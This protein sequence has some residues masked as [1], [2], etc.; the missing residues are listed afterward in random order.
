MGTDR[1]ADGILIVDKPEGPT[2]HDVVA[3]ARRLLGTRR[4][5][6]AGTLDPM[7]TGVLVLGYGRGTRLLPHL[8]ATRKAYL[9]TIRLGVA[10]T[11]DDRTG[12]RLWGSAAAGLTAQAVDAAAR[13]YVGRIA[14]R[15]S[16]V[17]AIKVAGRRAHARV[18]DG[19]RLDLPPREVTVYELARTGPLRRFGQWLDFDVTVVCSAGTYIRALARDI[20][21]DLGC[22]GHLT[23]LRRTAVGPFGTAEAA[24]LERARPLPLAEAAAAVMPTVRLGPAQAASVSHGQ[25]IPCDT[26]ASGPTALLGPD[27]D[28]LAVAEPAAGRWAYAAVYVGPGSGTL[29]P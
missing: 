21:E 22:G 20:G 8:A 2:S 11:T 13:R 25:Q 10:T 7:A 16:S 26:A 23:M 4:V 19:E 28:L 24:D 17:S 29:A 1:P 3:A 12:Q 27:G 5:G 6:H 14:Q 9:A 15:P 18:R